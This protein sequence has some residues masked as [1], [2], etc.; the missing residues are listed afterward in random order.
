MVKGKVGGAKPLVLLSRGE[1][2]ET[3]LPGHLPKYEHSPEKD[4]LQSGRLGTI[5]SSTKQRAGGTKRRKRVIKQQD[6]NRILLQFLFVQF[7]NVRR[8]EGKDNPTAGCKI[9][10]AEREEL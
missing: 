7:T 2:G 4:P 5:S 3:N 1:K 8:T 6:S 9:C 10:F